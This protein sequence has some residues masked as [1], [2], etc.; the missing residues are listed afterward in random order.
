MARALSED[1]EEEDR[2]VGLVFGLIIRAL[3][4]EVLRDFVAADFA[5]R[6]GLDL[7]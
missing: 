2:V 3:G 5:A 7:V 6:G 1:V 4:D